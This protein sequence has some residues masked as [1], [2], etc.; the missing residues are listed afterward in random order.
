MMSR[1]IPKTSLKN[2]SSPSAGSANPPNSCQAPYG[3]NLAGQLLTVTGGQDTSLSSLY[4][5]TATSMTAYGPVSASLGNG[6]AETLSFDALG[7]PAG[8]GLSQSNNPI[9]AWTATW[10]GSRVT[11]SKDSVNG[12]SA[13]YTYDDMNRLSAA[14]MGS[15]NLNWTYDRYGN[16]W[17]QS[18]SG[19]WPGTVL[20]PSLTF[21]N[22][23]NQ[24]TSSGYQY[25]VAGNLTQDPLHT[26]T[27]DAEGNLTA[28]DHGSTATF[29]YDALNQRVQATQNGA[30]QDFGFNTAGRRA[31]VWSATGS[32][33]SANY[34]A[35][36]A[37]LAYYLAA[38]GHAH[39]EHQDWIGTE[40]FR[41]KYNGILD[42]TF[43]SL[44]YGDGLQTTQGTDTDAS[45]YTGLDQDQPNLE[46]AGFRELSSAQGRW[47]R[48]DP[49]DGSYELNDPQSFNRY[50]YT[51]NNP[52]SRVD[53]LGLD[54]DEDGTGC[55][56]DDPDCSDSG[57]GGGSY[58]TY[59][60][61]GNTYTACDTCGSDGGAL[62]NGG[63]GGSVDVDSGDDD[64]SP[65]ATVDIASGFDPYMTPANYTTDGGPQVTNAD[66][67][68]ADAFIT[69]NNGISVGLDLLGF[70]VPEEEIPALAFGMGVS[71]A[72]TINSAINED[73]TGS[74]T[75]I[76]GFL[77][78][79][80]GANVKSIWA[81]AGS[82][83]KNGG[84]GIGLFSLNHD[85]DNYKKAYDECM[86]SLP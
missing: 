44:P 30:T 67:C 34:F 75:G 11:A 58:I 39:F 4:S 25:D 31:T 50:S 9:Y 21:S 17:S 26:Y 3:V 35:A 6:L 86:K 14:T 46:H 22:A 66:I 41:T 78:A 18:S 32:L 73:L 40:R 81:N 85:V 15:L 24:V 64:I 60:Q 80:I 56:N 62:I 36:G 82:Y 54:D 2:G 27:Y 29:L 8:L 1:K 71:F 28:I 49:Y 59:D 37:P 16:R 72:S 52:L 70:L 45:H 83:V 63:N 43:I 38:D 76:S 77:A 51:K 33:I 61:N 19:S 68:G 53:S 57:G 84:I 65:F 7:H 5:T 20:Q 79:P 69:N 10:S 23:T 74:M 47:L 55:G 42:G 12:G 48:P 13:S